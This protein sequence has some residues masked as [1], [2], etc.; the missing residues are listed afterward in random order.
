MPLWITELGW[1]TARDSFSPGVDDS[2]QGAYLA[3]A[4]LI[5]LSQGVERFYWYTFRDSGTAS[6]DQEQRFGM[7]SFD[8]IP[9]GEPEAQP[10]SAAEFST[11][12]AVLADHDTISDR[13]EELGLDA[14][15]WALELEGG[16]AASA[17]ALWTAGEPHTIE[18]G[19]RLGSVLL[20]TAGNELPLTGGPASWQIELS[21]RPVYLLSP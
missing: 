17:L 13:S 20:D 9:G 5:S 16:E 15:S 3:R 2:T 21:G 19:R 14:T 18:L 4:A 1:H 6:D 10:K 8:E 11:L 7:Y 12:S